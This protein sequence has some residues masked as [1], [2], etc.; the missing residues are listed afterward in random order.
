MAV[1]VASEDGSQVEAEAVDVVVGHPVAQA[2]HNHVTHIGVVAVQGIAA[3]TEIIVIALRG[4]HIIGLVVDAAIGDVGALL[5]ALS[6]VVEH[7]V[8]HHFNAVLMQ[9]FHHVLQLVHLHGEPA[10]RGVCG[11]GGKESYVAVAPQVVERAPIDR[12]DAVVFKLVELMD[13]HQF[14]A[15]DAQFLQIGNL[16]DDA[17]KRTLVL[18]ARSR[19][20][21]EVA[22]VHLIDD[23]V[24]D[25]RFQRKVILPVEV[26]EHHPGTILVETF[27]IGLLSPHITADYQLGVRVEQNLRLIEAVPFF[28]QER[29]IHAE[30]VLY[31]LII[32]V[33]NNH[34]KHIAQSELLEERYF[35]EGL[36]LT[37]MEEHQRA[38]GGIAG[39][40]REIHHIAN[41]RCAKRIRPARTQ[42]QSLVLMGWKQ[43][44]SMHNRRNC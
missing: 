13:G 1:L 33:E 14:H 25:G 9:L 31:V 36:F 17:G 44:D 10:R 2:L 28:R 30:T 18:H 16:L 34:R 7:H 26:G 21:R 35:H 6:G 38:I 11:L 8:E 41:D 4:Q 5:V 24:V 43:I 12:G 29:T 19:T 40:H 22:H 3:A 32:Q 27:P 15:V 39:I 37:I 23:E 20:T 42:F